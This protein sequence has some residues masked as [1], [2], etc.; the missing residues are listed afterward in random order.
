MAVRIVWRG[1]IYFH[2][3]GFWK[4]VLIIYLGCVMLKLYCSGG[5]LVVILLLS[6][7][8]SSAH[9]DV[10]D[11][12][13]LRADVARFVGCM[14][15]KDS[16]CIAEMTWPGV[17]MMAGGKK[18]FEESL[19]EQWMLTE[20]RFRVEIDTPRKI[21]DGGLVD[22]WL[23]PTVIYIEDSS[24]RGKVT[25]FTV[26]IK[27]SAERVWKYISGSGLKK[28][29]AAKQF[30]L[31]DLNDSIVLPEISIEKIY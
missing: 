23:I 11:V 18:A 15:V 22:I 4:L 10:L 3:G 5:R 19:S 12:E 20:G 9:A 28:S 27:Y 6:L 13:L 26:A 31:Y 17:T 2:F 29:P 1:V 8:V 24:S 30:L 21:G 25:T 14:V 7:F 16:A